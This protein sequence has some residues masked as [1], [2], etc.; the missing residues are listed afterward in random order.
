MS[1]VIRADPAIKLHLDDPIKAHLREGVSCLHVQQAVGEALEAIR[2]HP[3]EGR[4]IYFY[5]VDGDNRLHGVVPVRRLLLSPLEARVADIMVRE[6]I[7]ISHAATVLEACE[8]FIMHKLLA[9]PVVDEDHRIIGVVDVELYTTELSE[10]DRSEQNDYLFQ[11]IGVHLTEAQ[12]LSP[13]RAFRSRFPWLLCNIGGGILAAFLAGVF[14][15]ELERAVALALFIPVVLALA[16]SVSIQSVSLALRLLHGQAPTWPR[17]LH[18][19]KSEAVV[20]VLLG[21]ASASLVAIVALVWLGQVRVGLCILVGIAGGVAA[22]AVIGVALP[23][24]LHRLKLDPQVAAG[25]I[26]LAASDML[27]L[28]IYFNLARWLLA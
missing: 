22:A 24:L 9:F 16:E 10:L 3:P 28:L 12:Q 2:Q 6:V 5:V 27:T 21:S 17:I 14:A 25:P 8:F 15:A 7:T 4:V 11:L 19:L 13:L 26:A 1:S 23:N 20:G 18:K